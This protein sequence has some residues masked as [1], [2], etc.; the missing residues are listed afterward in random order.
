MESNILGRENGE[1]PIIDESLRKDTKGIE[2]IK[3]KSFLIH[4]LFKK[5]TKNKYVSSHQLASS[6]EDNL[7]TKISRWIRFN[8]ITTDGTLGWY[9]K[10]IN[11]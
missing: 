1:Y 8:L 9:P 10:A 4:S 7:I 3:I 5:N 6:N 11:V 2:A